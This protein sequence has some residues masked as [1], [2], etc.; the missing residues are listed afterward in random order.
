MKK[1]LLIAAAALMLTGTVSA[2]RQTAKIVSTMPAQR[3]CGTGILPDEYEN[4]ISAKMQE[5]AANHQ[6]SRIKTVYNLPV[7]VHVIHNGTAV[8]SSMNISDAQVLSQIEAL[9]EDYRKLNADTSSIPSVFAGLAAD[10]EINFCLAQ[11]DP[12]GLPT[13]G[14]NRI[15][16]NTQGWTA[17]PYA[18]TYVD[19]TIKP[20][21]IWDV[22]KYLNI[23]VCNLS[24]GLLGYA[25][26]PPSSTNLGLSA[27]FGTATSD[28]VVILYNSFGRVGTVSAPYNKGRT[29]THEIGHWFGLRH[30]NGDANCSSDYCNDTPTQASLNFGCPNFPKVSCSNGPNGDMFMNYMDYTDDACMFMFTPNQKA[31]MVTT[32]THT[33][34]RVN[35]AA[36]NRCNPPVVAAPVAAFT[37]NVTSVAVG[38]S[39]NFTDQ[40]TNSPTSWSWTFAGGTPA[41]STSQNPSGVVYNA[42]GTYAVTLTA[43]N[44]NGSNTLTQSTYI[45]VTGGTTTSS[46]DTLSN[47]DLAVMTPSIS[48][49][50]GW[51]YV[52]GQNDYLDVAK[53]DKFS[54]AGANSTIDGTYMAFGIGS[55]SGTG[56]TATVKVWSDAAGLP[57]TVLGTATISYDSIAAYAA[58]GAQMWVDFTPDIPVSVGDVYVGV[59]FGYTA[60]DTLALIHSADGEITPGTAYELWSDGTWHAYSETPASWGLNVAHLIRPV[61]CT[62]G[63]SSTTTCDSITN[64]DATVMTPSILGSSGWGYVSG[65]ND[66]LDVAKADAY[67]VTGTGLTVDGTYIAFGIGSSSGT[68]QTATVKVWSDAAGLPS[69][70]LGSAT[71]SYDSIAAYAASGSEMWVD[72][73]PD[74]PVTAG[75]IYVGVEFAYTAGDTLA[76]VHCADAEIATGTAYELWSDGTWHAYSETP[77]SWGVNVAHL[78]RPVVCSSTS[79]GV[80]ENTLG[81]VNL[82]PNPTRGELTVVL[83]DVTS[84]SDISFRI[85]NMVGAEVLTTSLPAN[86]NGTYHM[87]LSHLSQGLY[88][89]EINNATTKTVQKIQILK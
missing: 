40:S 2:Q 23:W 49:S 13:N 66:Y 45:T 24:G 29:A 12:N 76:I 30:I 26:F 55:S 58:S 80:A 27:P 52:S 59:E 88:F 68:G 37:S 83:S 25:T 18:K 82:F 47:F 81:A 86:G 54:I 16:R 35:L 56:Q 48:G 39:V 61:V 9:N 11:T 32:L 33:P 72:F 19:A 75:T 34:F 89:V 57:S 69:T 79:V 63:T 44:A 36:S 84:A 38:G 21:T 17:P 8:G 53:A 28:G 87:D 1:L 15:N 6:G 50:G 65:H 4:W 10:C 67:T 70:M 43:T 60:G 20:A 51:G 77:A 22:N 71:I 42:A 46:C 14:I 3:T 31:R 64:W 62:G 5:D 7:V 78:I 85:F 41:T 74:V 73:T